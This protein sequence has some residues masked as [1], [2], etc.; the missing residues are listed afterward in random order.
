L[1][2]GAAV[3]G[4]VLASANDLRSFQALYLF[5]A[6]TYVALALV[7]FV[8]VPNRRTA[9][10]EHSAKGEGVGA[11]A[12][13]WRV[14]IVLAVTLVL[15][16]VGY[17]LFANIL[18]PYASAHAH[19][20][21]GAIGIVFVFNAL[22]VAIAQVPAATLFKRMHRARTFAVASGLFAIALLAV[23]PATRIH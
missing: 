1:G 20:G 2:L 17:A 16:I 4:L 13:D 22:F 10:A 9:S 3:A 14:L 5:D 15:I 19:V 12:R 6:I 21:S 7:V 8:V 23:L 11:V 18:G